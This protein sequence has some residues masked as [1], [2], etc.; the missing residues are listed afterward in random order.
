LISHS[1][2]INSILISHSTSINSH[3]Y[4]KESL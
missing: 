3:W 4:P 2:S 1:T